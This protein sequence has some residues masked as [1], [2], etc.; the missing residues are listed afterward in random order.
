[1]PSAGGEYNCVYDKVS[2]MPIETLRDG[3]QG[4]YD[5]LAGARG[6]SRRRGALLGV[7][8]GVV[9]RYS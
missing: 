4:T 6:E 7:R 3:S 2:D 9:A 8:N 1:M 5:K